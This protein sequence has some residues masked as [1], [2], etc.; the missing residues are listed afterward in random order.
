MLEDKSGSEIF[1]ILLAA[2]KLGL[3]EIITHLQQFLLD[4]HVD[5]LKRHIETVNRASFRN[6][7][8]QV[9]QQF[10][11]ANDP[12]KVL[13]AINFDSISEN[14]MISLLKRN[15][16]GMDEVQI[17]DHVLKWG[18]TQNPT[19]S[20]MDPTKWIDNDFKTLQASLQQFLPLIGFHEMTGQQFFEKV[21]PFSKIFEPRVYEELVQYFMLS[22]KDVS[23]EYLGPSFGFDDITVN[24]E[25]YR[26]EMKCYSGN[27]SYEKPI[28]SEGY[29]L[30]DEYEIF[31][32]SEV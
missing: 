32:I 25:N 26:E 10:C 30:V 28:R 17:W 2:E 24:G 27:Y 4:Y 1:R 22:D 18:L 12:E 13:N 21:S 16:F 7:Y 14:A 9:L 3:Y 20:T 8:F 11:T 29:F 23:N 6:D 31:Q 19:M 5:W 15:H